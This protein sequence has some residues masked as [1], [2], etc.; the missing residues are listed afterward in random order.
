MAIPILGRVSS[1]TDLFALVRTLWAARADR[2]I[3]F[4]GQSALY[5]RV[6]SGRA[7][8]RHVV[9]EVATAWSRLAARM[10]GLSSHDAPEA[11]MSQ[12]ILQHYGLPTNFV[13]L[14]SDAGIA[15]F[16]ATS[17]FRTTLMNWVGTDFRSFE[18]VT[19]RPLADGDGHVLVL[20][21][22]DAEKL[23]KVRHLFCLTYLPREVLRPH[24]QLG[25]LFYDGPEATFDLNEFVL[26][27]IAIDRTTYNSARFSQDQLFPPPSEDVAYRDLLGF[28]WVQVPTLY[29]PDPPDKESKKPIHPQ[30]EKAFERHCF[31]YRALQTLEYFDDGKQ[32]GYDH[33]WDDLTLYEP[34]PVRMWRG[35]HHD[36]SQ[37]FPQWS[38][39]IADAVKITLS[40]HVRELLEASADA[41]LRWPDVEA[42]DIFFSFSQWGHDKVIDYAPP[43]H[44]VWLHQDGEW[45]V[46]TLT[47]A[48]EDRLALLAGLVFALS[49]KGLQVREMTGSC[50][51]GNA[52]SHLD[53]VKAML[54]L[55][56]LVS[57]GDITFVPHPVLLPRWYVAV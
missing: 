16:F 32:A 2:L 53:R 34:H 41:P 54:R 48:D 44:G 30:L 25:W 33:K 31:A 43:Y 17:E 1:E 45:I 26:G 38:G 27:T 7:R 21:I 28:P 51:C 55:S 13:D 37:R 3:L 52:Q 10:L 12:A 42:N 5:D 46:E 47:E 20:A 8:G 15:A 23:E 19:Y 29:F 14:T 56:A 40:E 57:S 36:L 49:D 50:E 39:D 35:W 11:R 22:P 6:K 9:P 24:R 18:R 4:R